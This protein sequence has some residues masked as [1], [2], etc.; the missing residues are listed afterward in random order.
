MI[1]TMAT[2]SASDMWSPA[3]KG[4]SWRNFSS[5]SFSEPFR[6]SKAASSFSW[7][8]STP[9]TLGIKSYSPNTMNSIWVS[10]KCRWNN[11][12]FNSVN[13]L[14]VDINSFTWNITITS[15]H[16]NSILTGSVTH[17]TQ[18]Q[19][20]HRSFK[21]CIVLRLLASCYWCH[22]DSV[23]RKWNKIQKECLNAQEWKQQEVSV[24]GTN[25][26]Q[27]RPGVSLPVDIT[28]WSVTGER[29]EVKACILTRKTPW[30]VSVNLPWART[31]WIHAYG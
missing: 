24:K 6:S 27:H 4:L 8:T 28:P 15:L 7:G 17:D 21:E 1:S 14:I 31:S 5:M 12:L 29:L 10:R 13:E 19:V 16:T 2:R 23:N 9:M 30:Q 25:W 3:M 20:C 26:Q 11:I 18:S 22:T